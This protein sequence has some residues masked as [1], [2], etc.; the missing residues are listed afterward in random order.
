MFCFIVESTVLSFG[1]IHSDLAQRQN[2]VRDKSSQKHH[3]TA[4]Y[5]RNN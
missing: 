4:D 2:R 1:I 5:S 3:Q